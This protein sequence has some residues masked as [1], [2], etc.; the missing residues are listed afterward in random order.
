VI[1]VHVWE[2]LSGLS[3]GL[4]RHG[5]AE[6]FNAFG[7]V[8]GQCFWIAA[9]AIVPVQVLVFGSALDHVVAALENGS[10]HRDERPL[11][12]PPARQT[13]VE[14]T[15]VGVFLP[16]GGVGRESPPGGPAAPGAL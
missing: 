9:L 8:P 10:A 3:Q 2:G 6:L 12:A 1:G 13:V 11:F 16:A 7:Q 15:Q 5:E 14:R 4:Q